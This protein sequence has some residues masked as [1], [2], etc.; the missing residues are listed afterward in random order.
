M[1][2]QPRLT[3]ASGRIARRLAG[4][5]LLAIVMAPAHS[6]GPGSNA[7]PFGDI[8]GLG[9]KFLQGQPL[10]ALPMLTDL[11]ARWVREHVS[12]S[13]VEP[14]SDQTPGRYVA[15][16]E[17]LRKQLAFY[18]ANDIG[19]VALLT[20]S[21]G[22][23]V[24][25]TTAE[26]DR[27]SDP[28]AFGRFAAEA[29]RL[30]KAEGVRFVLEVGNEP[31]NSH[32]RKVLGGHWN[33]K[34]PSPWLD[35]YVRMVN[36][37][38]E[39]VK[40]IDPGVKVI[41]GDDMWVVGY[42][43]LAAGLDPRLDGLS[44]HPYTPGVPEVA[45]VAH[46]TDWI[47][48]LVVVD[49]DRSL[50]SAIA[51]LRAAALQKQGRPLEIW[52]TEMGWPVAEGTR[53]AKRSVDERTAA[54][55]LPRSFIL[56]A[57][58]GVEGFCWF[59]SNDSVDGPMG[60]TRNDGTRRLAYGAFKTMTTELG[61]LRFVR[62]LLGAQG[63]AAAAQA[64]LFAD[65]HVRTIVA[66]QVEGHDRSA[67]V[68]SQVGAGALVVTDLLGNRRTVETRGGRATVA[69]GSEPVYVQLPPGGATLPQ[70]QIHP[71]MAKAGP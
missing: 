61:T 35:H 46:D 1:L 34:P 38:V 14:S 69:L 15:L 19:V 20:L 68:I 27:F 44:V 22:K 43:L 62:R 17:N 59:S 40:A 10:E 2:P 6:A 8:V 30:L 58:A 7:R 49:P 28:A 9:V 18:R 64:F 16:P 4:A 47:R 65:E 23:T 36:A 45:A 55:Y 60:L 21:N 25:R 70:I 26:V 48:P 32:L 11:K 63:T 71:A 33:G 31:H 66:W 57:E 67:L 29:A 41:A 54:A 24:P 42:R 51:R 50:Q 3:G 52:I 12:W 39:E 13:S 53:P 37:A 5:L 56:A